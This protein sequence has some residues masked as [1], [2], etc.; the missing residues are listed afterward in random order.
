MPQF[1]STYPY[2]IHVVSLGRLVDVDEV[3]EADENPDAHFFVEVTPEP[4]V[5]STDS[6]EPKE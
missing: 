5:P 6:D 4:D 1:K 3:V 2:A